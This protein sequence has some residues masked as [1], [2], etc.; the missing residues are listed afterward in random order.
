MNYTLL[1]SSNINVICNLEMFAGNVLELSQLEQE[2][3]E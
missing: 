1:M 3:R 2:V